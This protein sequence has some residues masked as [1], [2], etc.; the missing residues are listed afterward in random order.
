MQS[1]GVMIVVFNIEHFAAI[2]AYYDEVEGLIRHIYTS[3]VDPQIGEILLPGEPEFRTQR[4]RQAE[5]IEVDP[6]T[7]DRIEEAAR[8]LALDPARWESMQR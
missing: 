6:T 3:R 4:Q 8:R 2:D 5:G 1:N 7:W